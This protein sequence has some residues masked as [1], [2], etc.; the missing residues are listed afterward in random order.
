MDDNTPATKGDLQRLEMGLEKRLT[1][2]M[3]IRFKSV[4]EGIDQVL[5]VLIHGEKRT[6]RKLQNHEQRIRVIE[7]VLA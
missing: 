3:D 1:D 6:K 4:N 2:S 5:D 7:K